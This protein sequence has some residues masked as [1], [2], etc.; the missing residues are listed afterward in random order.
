MYFHLLNCFL[1]IRLHS[2]SSLFSSKY[3]VMV[4]FVPK[5]LFLFQIISLGLDFREGL[6]G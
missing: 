2:V 1:T 4:I 3:P 5:Y 6:V